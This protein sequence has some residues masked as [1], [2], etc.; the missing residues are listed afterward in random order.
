MLS[1]TIPCIV[2]GSRLSTV[3]SE[4]QST[5]NT[6]G[7]IR[8]ACVSSLFLLIL[9]FVIKYIH[10]SVPVYSIS[11]YIVFT[12]AIALNYF[13]QK[14]WRSVI[15]LE[16]SSKYKLLIPSVTVDYDMKYNLY[17]LITFPVSVAIAVGLFLTEYWVFNNIF[18][19]CFVIYTI[20]HTEITSLKAGITLLACMVVYD[21]LWV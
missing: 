10:K 17:D 14:M 19:L 4:P 11:P 20:E 7:A 9:Y 2:L 5:L 16:K 12:A 6:S 13:L 8:F 3:S 1:L 18:A 21:L 15:P